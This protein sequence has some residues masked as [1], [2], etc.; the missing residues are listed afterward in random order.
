MANA[1]QSTGHAHGIDTVSTSQQHTSQPVEM[2]DLDHSKSAGAGAAAAPSNFLADVD[3]PSS[4]PITTEPP[5]NTIISSE[6]EAKGKENMQPGELRSSAARGESGSAADKQPVAQAL[7]DAPSASTSTPE[8]AKESQKLEDSSSAAEASTARG[9]SYDPDNNPA[10]NSIAGQDVEPGATS[11]GSYNPAYNHL[12][13]AELAGSDGL[14][15]SD[16]RPDQPTAPV[17]SLP[18][19]TDPDLSLTITLLLAS[20]S[21]HPYKIDDKYLTKRNVDVPGTTEAGK[22]DPYS[23][24]V[25]MLKE[26]IL[27]EWREEWEARPSNSSS[28][29]L[30][31][32][33]RLLTDKLVLRDCKFSA[34]SSNVVHMSIIPQDIVDEEDASKS[35]AM[36]R[37]RDGGERTA[38]CRCC[39]ALLLKQKREKLTMIVEFDISLHTRRRGLEARI[40][41]RDTLTKPAFKSL[42][43]P[44]GY[45]KLKMR[46]YSVLIVKKAISR[47]HYGTTSSR[48]PIIQIRNGTFYRHHPNSHHGT[49]KR[50]PPLFTNLNFSLPSFSPTPEYWSIIGPSSSGK[51]TF[52]QI[53]REHH[54]AIPPSARTYPYLSTSEIEQK[55]HALR[56]PNK[57]VKYVGFDGDQGLGAQAPKG[58][59][60]SARYESRREETDFSV[61]D[62]LQGNTELNPSNSVDN[63]F[64]D[65]KTLDRVIKDL[66]LGDLVNLPVSN[67]SNGQTRRARIARALLGNPEVLL[68]DEP[69]MGLDP[70][71]LLTLSPML[72][73]LAQANSPR[74]V[75]TLRPQDPIPEWI[76]HVVLLRGNCEV[77]FQGRKED[78]LGEL[79]GMRKRDLLAYSM[80]EIR[81]TLTSR[82]IIATSSKSKAITPSKPTI[83]QSNGNLLSRDGYKLIDTEPRKLGEPLVEMKGARVAY[84]PKTV[85]GNWTQAVNGISKDGLW[86]TVRKGERWGI[87]GPNGSGKTTILSLICSDHPQTYSLPI[88][89]FGRTRL[90]EPGQPGISIFDIQARIGHSS[91]EIHNHIPTSMTLRQVLEN[92]WSD[93]FRGV[94]KL[95][96]DAIERIDAC[97]RWFEED[98]RPGANVVK[99]TDQN[100][101]EPPTPTWANDVLFGGLPFSAQRVALFLRAVIK[102]PEL[103]ILDEAFS[104]MDNGVR[105]RCLLFLAHGESKEFSSSTS[106]PSSAL[107]DAP[108]KRKIIPSTIF[109]AGRVKPGLGD[110]RAQLR[111]MRGGPAISLFAVYIQAQYLTCIVVPHISKWLF[112]L[113]NLP[114][115]S[116]YLA[117]HPQ[118]PSQFKPLVF[119]S[120]LPGLLITA[121]ERISNM[122][123]QEHTA[124]PH[125][126]EKHKT[127]AIPQIPSYKWRLFL[128]RLSDQRRSAPEDTIK[129]LRASILYSSHQPTTS[130]S[131]IEM[132]SIKPVI[133]TI[134]AIT[135]LVSAGP[136]PNE[137]VY[138]TN[139]VTPASGAAFSRMDYYSNGKLNSQSLQTPTDSMNLTTTGWQI[140]EGR[141]VCGPFPDTG[142]IFCSTIE[143]NGQAVAVG[144]PAGFGSN[145]QQAFNCFKDNGRILYTFS[146]SQC[147]SQ[148]YCFDAN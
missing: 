55:D 70:P 24:T 144:A 29:R 121:F 147:N 124:I 113:N 85:L 117:L 103:V 82:R 146:G 125:M 107:E 106:S 30:I 44:D 96:D 57:A 87:F 109:Q 28:I 5:A 73:G 27:R 14:H 23:L 92:A 129:H 8:T 134:L 43:K 17:P 22:K 38:G 93:T 78:V 35:K 48:P 137:A 25:Y 18:D 77:A 119:D 122:I 12:V 75:L 39:R 94:P 143:S 67:L 69:F 139:C 101:Q 115:Q 81:Q 19:E 91:P 21:R 111:G 59:Y 126:V 112:C 15:G 47:R 4:A 34:E 80:G 135:S 74:L 9:P 68:L 11:I 65:S 128:L 37:D 83:V 50:N 33:G 84:G 3:I 100:L 120:K 118:S 76:T 16:Q 142:E 54:L 53:L 26:L 90:P 63:R 46:R 31:Y 72:Y 20:G 71:T 64:F 102:N 61:L 99:G 13:V 49:S 40:A 79:R 110:L 132:L 138:L 130:L 66:R 7:S 95:N 131:S 6:G 114:D 133:L 108:N 141:Q 51:T 1:T 148:Y 60:L 36:T 116:I 41:S 45:G 140:W 105:D 32:F 136:I 58:A 123:L 56:V 104:G 86:W 98:L 42:R 97:L 127:R 52:L 62:Y 88:W 145:Q 89:L 10:V 2:S